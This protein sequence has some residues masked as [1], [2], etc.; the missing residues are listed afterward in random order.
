[1]LALSGCGKAGI[2]PLGMFLLFQQQHPTLRSRMTSPTWM[3]CS[4]GSTVVSLEA[5]ELLG[6]GVCT[7]W[8]WEGCDHHLGMFL[9]FQKWRV[10]RRSPSRTRTPLTS[11][12]KGPK[13]L[14]AR[15]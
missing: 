14:L 4:R 7:E 8:L 9:A 13:M 15:M 1:M 11:K 5:S 10:F 6:G 2:D 3:I 12:R